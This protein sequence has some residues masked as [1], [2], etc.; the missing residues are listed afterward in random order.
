MPTVDEETFSFQEFT[1]DLRRGCLRDAAHEI[2]LRPKSFAVLQ[3][4][5]ANAGRLVSKDELIALVWANVTVSDVSLARCI[6]DVRQALRDQA[7]QIIRTVPRRGY[8]FAVPVSRGVT[9]PS[10]IDHESEK[11]RSGLH[12]GE[13]RQLTILACELAS[14]AELSARL[15]PEDLRQATSACYRRCTDIV[16][17]HHG[18]V[19]HDGADG[20][21]AWFGYPEAE[22]QDAENALR[23]A[24]ALQ[25]S[26]AQLSRDLGARIQPSIGIST[27]IVVIDAEPATGE[28]KGVGEPL[29]LAARILAQAEPGQIIVSQR[30]RG[31]AGGFFEYQDLGL[32]TLKGLT[33][34]VALARVV[35]ESDSENRFEAFHPAGLTPLVGREEEI[36]L[37]LQRWQQ[38]KAGEGLH[39]FAGGR[40]RYR[41][42]AHR[43]DVAG[44][45]ARRGP[46]TSAPV[47][48]AVPSG[49]PALPRNRSSRARGRLAAHGQ[50]RTTADPAGDSSGP[51]DSRYPRR[52][53]IAGRTARDAVR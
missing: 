51:D 22:E 25:A 53:A 43:A 27:G 18:Y 23:A 6:S 33:A 38:A 17:R 35:G 13:S 20:L 7:Q 37:L 11:P 45:A 1:L 44:S 8:L 39:R 41:Q 15:D 30:T 29:T 2:E 3:H 49:Q 32:V 26:A 4:L 34:P 19:A 14:L 16:E 46:R 28:R 12:A 48:R 36:A 9:A 40:A 31:V 42:V 5:V 47:L 52:R 21:L 24:L 10:T 50:Q